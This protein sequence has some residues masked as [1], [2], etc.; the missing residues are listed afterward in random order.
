[1]N[2]FVAYCF[3]KNDL[4]HEYFS[5]ISIANPDHLFWGTALGDYFRVKTSIYL[6]ESFLTDTFKEE[7]TIDIFP[8]ST[9]IC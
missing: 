7:R 3:A 9:Q 8:N 5:W 1:M 2:S 4:L 6:T